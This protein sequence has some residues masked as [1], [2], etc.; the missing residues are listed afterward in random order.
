MTFLGALLSKE[1]E[2]GFTLKYLKEDIK[3]EL[4]GWISNT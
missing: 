3:E 4:R 2:V 1:D